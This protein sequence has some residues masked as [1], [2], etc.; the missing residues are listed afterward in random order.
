MLGWN[1]YGSHKTRVRTPYTEHVF[2]NPVE[3]VGHVVHS[4][5]FGAQTFDAPFFMLRWDRFGFKKKCDGACY[6]EVVFLHPVG[7]TG[8]RVHCDASGV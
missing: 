4:S 7:S 3:Y 5:A 1:W 8:H 2:L 6:A